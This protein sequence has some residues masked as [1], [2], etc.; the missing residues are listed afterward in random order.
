MGDVRYADR[1]M[2]DQWT[3]IEIGITFEQRHEVYTVLMMLR[4]LRQPGHGEEREIE[5]DPADR[6][7]AHRTRFDHAGP[8]DDARHANAAFV[9][10]SLEAARGRLFVA[11]T[12]PPLSDVKMT[13]VFSRR[14]F[15]LANPASVPRFHPA[16]R[17]S[18]RRP[19]LLSWTFC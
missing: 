1:I 3:A 16:I 13:I 10:V 17:P 6:C 19:R 4:L 7:V 12:M 9:D 8:V 2:P 15:R 18:Q 14:F 5:I 11:F